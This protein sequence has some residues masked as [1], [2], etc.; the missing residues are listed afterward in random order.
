[1]AQESIYD[2][3]QYLGKW[4]GLEVYEPV[5]NDDILRCIGLP[6]FI[7]ASGSELR[8]TVETDESLAIMEAFPSDD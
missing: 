3:V 7:L 4:K 5:F 1:M 6:Q 2:D 8:W